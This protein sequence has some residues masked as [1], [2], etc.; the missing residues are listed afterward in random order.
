MSI[1]SHH[2]EI[3]RIDALL[4]E[5]K[6]DANEHSALIAALKGKA[7][8]PFSLRHAIWN[9]FQHLSNGNAIILGAFFVLTMAFLASRSPLHFP[10][11]LDLQL[12]PPGNASLSFANLLAQNLVNIASAALVF[13]GVCKTFKAKNLRFMDFCASVAFARLPYVLLTGS[14]VAGMHFFPELAQ[15]SHFS[16]P[17]LLTLAIGLACMA[18][19]VWEVILLFSAF[20]ESSGLLGQRLWTIFIVSL[21]ASEVVSLTITRTI[22]K[23]GFKA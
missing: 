10:G 17:T 22:L 12:L 19:L 7:G 9:P 2:D 20:K 6:I 14:L 4:E 16:S 1:T 23:Q 15:P 13:F 5:G 8:T 18:F 11:L 21:I 3:G